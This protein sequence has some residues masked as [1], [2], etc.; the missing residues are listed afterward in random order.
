AREFDATLFVTKSEADLFR[1]LAPES[2]AKI[3]F[4][5]NGVDTD[6][7]DPHVTFDSPYSA[8]TT[9]DRTRARPVAVFTGAMD[10]WANVDAVQWFV[11]AVWPLVRAQAPDAQ[12]Y[13]VGSNPGPEVR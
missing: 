13:I 2:A 3:G 1:S 8:A 4:F 9:A 5:D 6:Y 7:F 11:D 12:F 10:Y